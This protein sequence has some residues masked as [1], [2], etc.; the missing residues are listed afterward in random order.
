M[1]PSAPLNDDGSAEENLQANEK[2]S[3]EHLLN[4]PDLKTQNSTIK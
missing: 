1:D 2:A 3:E 4:I